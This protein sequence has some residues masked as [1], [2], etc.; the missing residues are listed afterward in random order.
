MTKIAI[1]YWG[2]TRSAKFVYNSHIQNLYNVLKENNI[3]YKIYMHTW[4]IDVST[5]VIA[6]NI[7]NLEIDYNEYKFLNPDIYIIENQNDFLNT[8]H[9]GSY[10]NKELYDTYGDNPQYEW[11]P[12][13]IRNH[14]C[15]LESQKRVY[16]L[17]L[18]DDASFDFLMF[19]RPDV[20]IANEFNINWLKQDFDIMIPNTDHNEGLNDRFAIMPFNKSFKYSTRIDEIIEYRKNN[21]RIVSEKYI[22]YIIDKYYSKLKFINF[23]M[24]IIRPNG[25]KYLNQN[26]I[27]SY[28]YYIKM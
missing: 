10:F 5:N 25:E 19:I 23:I 8:I 16:K 26:N 15:A 3:D 21:G 24:T 20:A 28:D 4:K 7:T 17:V 22:K 9:F 18:E 27:I 12:Q 13:L 1:C 14:L 6:Q 2:M 11:K